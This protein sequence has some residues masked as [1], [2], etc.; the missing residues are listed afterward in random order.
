[1]RVVVDGKAGEAVGGEIGAE[2]AHLGRVAGAPA[3]AMEGDDGEMG[4][5]GGWLIEIGLIGSGGVCG[6]GEIS[7]HV[8]V[9]GR[10]RLRGRYPFVRRLS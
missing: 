4:A 9:S 6:V 1:M 8:R 7:G 10:G 5:G 3:S 2:T